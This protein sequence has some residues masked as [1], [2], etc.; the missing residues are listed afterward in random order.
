MEPPS[1]RQQ[2]ER[3]FSKVLGIGQLRRAPKLPPS[4]LA[5]GGPAET[6]RVEFSTVSQREGIDCFI[7]ET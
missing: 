6:S 3:K 1:C 4:W 2:A 5:E 7:A